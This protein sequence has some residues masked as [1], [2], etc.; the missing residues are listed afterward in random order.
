MCE[1]DGGDVRRA[2][3]SWGV[4][5][6]LPVVVRAYQLANCRPFHPYCS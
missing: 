3:L 4:E 2:L 5:S 6:A 1:R